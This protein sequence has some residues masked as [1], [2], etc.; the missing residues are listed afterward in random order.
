MSDDLVSSLLTRIDEIEEAARAASGRHGEAG[1][2]DGER[3]HWVHGYSDDPRVDQ[4]ID[5][6]TEGAYLADGGEADLRSV[7]EYP[8]DT[9]GPLPHFVLSFGQEVEVG[10]ARHIPMHDPR[11][12]LRLCRAHRHMVEHHAATVAERDRLRALALSPEPMSEMDGHYLGR[13]ENEVIG[14]T[15]LIEAL[16]VGLG[17]QEDQ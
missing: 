12:I 2:P 10:V 13:A 7:E 17:L 11:S 9:V 16:A 14:Q 8:T 1:P 5:V 15:T 4:P 6:D 3:W